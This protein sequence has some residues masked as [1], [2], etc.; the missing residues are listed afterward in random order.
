[1]LNR[2]K[3]Q[4]ALEYLLLI[5]GAVVVAA[6]VIVLLLGTGSTS[7]G[8][9]ESGAMSATC[10]Q[11]AI[12]ANPSNPKCIEIDPTSNQTAAIWNSKTSTCWTCSGTYPSC[13]AQRISPNAVVATDCNAGTGNSRYII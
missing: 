12:Q 10:A 9:T 11:L 4:G 8:Q 7:G 1:M 2:F 13:S 6:V 3:G 5:G